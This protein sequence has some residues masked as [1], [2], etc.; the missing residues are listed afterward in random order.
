MVRSR[1]LSRCLTFGSESFKAMKKAFAKHLPSR[2][3]RTV[4]VKFISTLGYHTC[5]VYLST[6]SSVRGEESVKVQAAALLVRDAS[7]GQCAGLLITACYGW[8]LVGAEWDW[9]L[10]QNITQQNRE[11]MQNSR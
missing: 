11:I 4:I 5:E 1:T 2:S 3:R 7:P 10:E 9:T 8:S 6:G